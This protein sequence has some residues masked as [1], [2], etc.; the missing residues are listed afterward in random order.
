MLFQAHEYK[1]KGFE[2]KF[3]D[4]EHKFRAFELM[5]Q[6]L[7]QKIPLEG[8]TFP[9]HIKKIYPPGYSKSRQA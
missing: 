5:F 8:K 2:H 7:E 4:L 1:F 6:G 3:I 9:S